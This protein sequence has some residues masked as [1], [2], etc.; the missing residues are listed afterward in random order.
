M[1]LVGGLDVIQVKSP[2]ERPWSAM[3]GDDRVRACGDCKQNV[4]NL[5]AMTREEAEAL[6]GKREGRMCVRFFRRADGTISTARCDGVVEFTADDAGAHWMGDMEAPPPSPPARELT[7]DPHAVPRDL[8][9]AEIA[10]SLRHTHPDTAES[11]AATLERAWPAGFACQCAHCG[12]DY[13]LVFKDDFLQPADPYA[14]LR[15][16]EDSLTAT[17]P[18][19]AFTLLRELRRHELSSVTGG[20]FPCSECGADVFP[21]P[22]LL[23]TS[24]GR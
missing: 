22:A 24:A 8:V 12:Y 15:I 4:Y 20:K 1:A 2:C 5:S 14:L 23:P 10:R 7:A 9:L 17:R 21:P 3:L 18:T 13:L 16:I 19:D 11:L 6:I